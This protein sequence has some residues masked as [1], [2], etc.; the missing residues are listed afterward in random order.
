MLRAAGMSE[1]T[2]RGILVDNPRRFLSFTPKI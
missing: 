1:S 2:L